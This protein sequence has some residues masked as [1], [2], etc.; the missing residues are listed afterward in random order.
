MVVRDCIFDKNDCTSCVYQ[1]T[2]T[3]DGND[4]GPGG[5]TTVTISNT[6]F[7]SN[8]PAN[9]QLACI[10]IDTVKPVFV[11]MPYVDSL[12][13]NSRNCSKL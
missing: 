6:T 7:R 1:S 10:S 2:L 9:K 3:V 12:V 8:V 11:S 13:V 5:A 4:D